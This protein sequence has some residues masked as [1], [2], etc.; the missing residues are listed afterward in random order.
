MREAE[1]YTHHAV[2][3]ADGT[4]IGYRQLGSGPGLVLLHGG[5]NAAQHMMRMARLLAD[6]FT[7]YLPDRRGRGT[8]GPYG[9]AYRIEREDDDLAAV[10]HATGARFVFGPANG[11]LFALHGSIALTQVERVVAYEPLLFLGQ[12]GI[13]QFHALFVTMQDMIRAGRLGDAMDYSAA[14]MATIEA[15]RGAYPAWTAAVLRHVP[16]AAYNTFLRLERPR[17]GDVAWRDLLHALPDELKLVIATDG[18]LDSY[19][20]LEAATLLLHGAKSHPVFAATARALH[21]VL[22]NSKVVQLPGLNHDAAQTYGHPDAIA[23]ATRV[24]LS[25]GAPDVR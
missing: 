11:A 3:S 5:T 14:Q 18:T 24:F 8:S 17:R 21:E 10:V 2:A 23:A 15:Q 13:D 16:A 19:R 1:P 20:Q 9:P 4:T 7:V 25:Q 12:P 22:P 6:A